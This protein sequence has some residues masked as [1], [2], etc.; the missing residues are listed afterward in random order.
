MATQVWFKN[1]RTGEH[2]KLKVG[3]SWTCFFFWAIF[4]IPLF[5][6]KL[7][8]WGA[9]GVGYMLIHY[10]LFALLPAALMYLGVIGLGMSVY[11]GRKANEMAA[12]N[13]LMM[14]WE[15]TE[16]DGPGTAE[17]VARWGLPAPNAQQPQSQQQPPPQGTTP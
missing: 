6:R 2:K 10:A 14:G 1:P 7:N 9:V 3:F 11:L 16:P 17:A 13:Y 12:R 8:T 15:F 5:V 4:G